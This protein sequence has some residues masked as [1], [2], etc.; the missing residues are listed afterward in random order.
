MAHLVTFIQSLTHWGHCAGSKCHH[1]TLHI[2][3]CPICIAHQFLAHHTSC[4]LN[5]PL[6]HHFLTPELFTVTRHKFQAAGPPSCPATQG[7]G[8]I[9]SVTLAKLPFHIGCPT[10]HTHTHTP[11]G[12]LNN[13]DTYPSSAAYWCNQLHKASVCDGTI[14]TTSVHK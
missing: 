10:W 9:R 1:Q 7:L 6:K 3:E 12:Q 13:V 11:S 5:F 8:C 2:C 4:H 14:K